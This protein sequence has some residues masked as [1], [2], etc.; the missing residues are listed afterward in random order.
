[1]HIA[2]H[3]VILMLFH[4]GQ[5][6]LS[7][8]TGGS[9]FF[10][11]AAP[12]AHTGAPA[13]DDNRMPDLRARGVE[14]GKYLSVDDDA[15]AD[16]RAQRNGNG[17]LCSLRRTCDVFAVGCGIC[18]VLNVHAA[19]QQLFHCRYQR[20]VTVA[21]VGVELHDACMRVHTAR[22]ADAH[23]FDLR[24]HVQSCPLCELAAQRG[25]LRFHLM[26][27]PRQI[28]L[29]GN[30]VHD[31]MCFIYKARLDICAAQV[32]T[33]GICFHSSLLPSSRSATGF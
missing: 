19:R 32:D 4:R 15:A 7:Q 26:L 21:E 22:R 17:V 6:I 1:M 12:P 2:P 5:S 14:A 11:A 27:R 18:I 31:M 8:R 10:P 33:D 29:A 3:D 24:G 13:L 9:I 25:D 23:G 16:A 30:A 20:P 28:C